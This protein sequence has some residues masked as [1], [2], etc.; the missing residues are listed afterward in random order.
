MVYASGARSDESGP[1]SQDVEIEFAGP[2]PFSLVRWFSITSFVAIVVVGVSVTWFRVQN[3]TVNMLR[4][5]AEVSRQF[6]ESIAAAEKTTALLLPIGS[7]PSVEALAP[8]VDHLPTLPDLVRANFYAADR[9]ILWSTDR[10]LIGK[11]FEANEE[12]ERAFGGENVVESGRVTADDNK[13]EHLGLSKK[14]LPG[15][16][17]RFVEA[18]LP[19]RDPNSRNVIAV[20]EIYKT[21]VSLFETIDSSIY[22]A[23]SYG[24]VAALLLYLVFFAIVRRGDLLMRAQRER[25]IEA[26]TLTAVGEMAA[27]VAHSIR[28]PLASIRSA[29]ELAREEDPRGL[30]E[31]LKDIM[32]EADRIDGWVRELLQSART[33]I[34]A[35][36]LI[37]LNV[38]LEEL[39]QDS[40][41]EMKRRHID[42]TFQSA[43][44]VHVRGDRAPLEHAIRAVVS[45]AIFSM[46]EGGKLHVESRIAAKRQVQIVVEDTGTG[47]PEHAIRRAFHPFFTTRPNGIG[48]GLSLA[49]RVLERHAGDIVL[50]SKVGRGTKVVLSLPGR[51]T[52]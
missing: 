15:P 51:G 40:V 9:T 6:L 5:D 17:T 42:L 41:A 49:R 28:N 20:V 38:L 37:D 29:A 22:V 24:A 27:A 4:R 8:F 39:L 32:N 1:R 36:E 21:P 16:G 25:L 33:T 45:N 26:E 43:P 10:Q 18:Y 50:D 2:P 23:W 11:K 44:H 31:C 14:G 30:D 34:A 19:L 47:M 46:P 7:R 13:E 12:L 52:D 48:L 35:P 3:L